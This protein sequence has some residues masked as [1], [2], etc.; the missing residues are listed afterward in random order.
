MSCFTFVVIRH[1]RKGCRDVCCIC[2]ELYGILH[3]LYSIC[4]MIINSFYRERYL[5]FW[6]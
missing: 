6:I 4:L 5:K 3:D 1:S 2:K